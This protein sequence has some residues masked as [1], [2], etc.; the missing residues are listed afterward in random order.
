M[1]N[2]FI[3][4]AAGVS[5]RHPDSG[6]TLAAAGENVE[7][8]SYWRRRERDG[9]VTIKAPPPHKPPT[10]TAAASAPAAVPVKSK[11]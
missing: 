8:N 6:K 9:D 1:T 3:T 11:K 7:L 2:V 5:V 10:A 4:P